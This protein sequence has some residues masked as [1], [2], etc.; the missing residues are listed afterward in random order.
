MDK[1]FSDFVAALFGYLAR[2]ADA[3]EKMADQHVPIIQ[4]PE[5][6]PEPTPE[7]EPEPEPTPTPTPVPTGM[8]APADIPLMGNNWAT[9]NLVLPDWDGTPWNP[10]LVRM[11]ADRSATLFTRIIGGAWRSGLMQIF[12]PT[13][14]I[15]EVA[16]VFEVHDPNGVAAFFTFSEKLAGGVKDG[17]ECDFELVRRPDGSLAWQLG[18]HQFTNGQ[19]RNPT[20]TVFVPVTREHLA[21]PHEYKINYQRDFVAYIIDGREVGRYTPADMPAGTTW[22][23]AARFDTFVGTYGHT[24]WSG[25]NSADKAAPTTRMEVKGLRVPGL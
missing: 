24:G 5:P 11:N 12:R 3:L 19:R 4:V 18:L 22:Q 1:L 8:R 20:R 25:F 6:E 23:L 10:A 9:G 17:T 7:P 14:A 13:F 15:G 16:A 21:Q 2:I